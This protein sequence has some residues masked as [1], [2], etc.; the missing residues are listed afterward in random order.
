MA[1]CGTGGGGSMD[2]GSGRPDGGGGVLETPTAR[3]ERLVRDGKMPGEAV[4]HA[5]RI[6]W[7][8]LRQGVPMPNGEV[9]RITHDDLLHLIVDARVW[10]HPDRIEAAIGEVFEIRTAEPDRRQA[11]SRWQ[12]PEGERLATFII[13]S[14]GTLRALHLIDAKRMA[15]YTR[16][17]G[18]V[19]WRR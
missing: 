18:D 8:R 5:E 1:P 12:E 7:E 4:E 13:A 16:R 10:R 11:F 15:R 17:G 3:I 14:D 6:W 9:V 19:L 2:P